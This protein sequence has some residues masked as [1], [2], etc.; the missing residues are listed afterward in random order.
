MSQAEIVVEDID[1]ED[2]GVS[3]LGSDPMF[4]SPASSTQAST[5]VSLTSE[6]NILGAHSGSDENLQPQSSLTEFSV[7]D[8][9]EPT[10]SLTGMEAVTAVEVHGAPFFEFEETIQMDLLGSTEL[11]LSAPNAVYSADEGNTHGETPLEYEPF[12]V[13]V[14]GLFP[15]SNSI[16][17]VQVDELQVPN[18]MA[19]PVSNNGQPFPLLPPEYG[20]LSSVQLFFSVVSDLAAN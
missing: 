2:G 13:S 4:G 3:V 20:K 6:S 18:Q 7:P 9:P 15:P 8:L 16:F 12:D 19:A 10:V 1:S 11:D 17:G 5:L 14:A